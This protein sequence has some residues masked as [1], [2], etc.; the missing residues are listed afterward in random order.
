VGK[1]KREQKERKGERKKEKK[2]N[3]FF[4]KVSVIRETFLDV[5]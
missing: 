1:K 2:E 4:L 3:R 5:P